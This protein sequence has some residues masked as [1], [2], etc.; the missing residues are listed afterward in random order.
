MPPFFPKRGKQCY[1]V[2]RRVRP[3]RAN[4]NGP[5]LPNGFSEWIVYSYSA[6]SV[7]IDL[8][9]TIRFT[10]HSSEIINKKWNFF[11]LNYIFI[12]FFK[13]FMYPTNFF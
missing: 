10:V 5:G 7:R 11:P 13:L 1:I 3:E 9:I 8:L 4:S 2:V 6:L 12:T